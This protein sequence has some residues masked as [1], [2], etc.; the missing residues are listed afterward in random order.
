METQKS[1]DT[2]SPVGKLNTPV[3]RRHLLKMMAGAGALAIV[4]AS[5]LPGKVG[6]QD[7][8][9]TVGGYYRTTTQLNL[10]EKPSTS[11]KILLVMQEN[12]LVEYLGE[13]KNGFRK[14][15]H[16]GTAGWAHRDYLTVSNG[17]SSD[18]PVIVGQGVT[19]TSVNFRTGPTTG[20]QVIR[21]LA[22]GTVVDVSDTE[23]YGFRYAVHNGRGGW[24]YDDYLAPYGGEG[25]AV[26]TTTSAVNL[27]A[28]P[29]TSAKILLVVKQGETVYDYDLEIANG[30]RS[31]DYKGTVG[32]IYNTYLE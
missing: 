7:A 19:T 5:A 22:R 6:A 25:P 12:A 2:L 26:F 1:F 32:W 28:K 20:H 18:P 4:G 16:Q 13:T 23:R 29:S 11:A 15:A 14:V 24:I 8:E 3:G 21:V 10:R 9:A 27:R 17:G 30:F 31:V